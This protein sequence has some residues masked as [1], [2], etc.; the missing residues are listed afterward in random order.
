MNKKKQLIVSCF[1]K[2]GKEKG[3]DEINVMELVQACGVSR[4]TF[5]YHFRDIPDVIE[6]SVMERMNKLTEES[7]KIEDPLQAIE[8]ITTEII[9]RLQYLHDLL[10]T[11]WRADVE[12]IMYKCERG[13]VKRIIEERGPSL[14]LTYE[15]KEFLIDFLSWG[16]IAYFVRKG[17]NKMSVKTYSKQ[18]YQLIGARLG[19][20]E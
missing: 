8:F 18:F 15:E 1:E 20:I 14:S 13:H 9:Q 2:L 17:Y 3:F 12:Q 5:Y 7:L 4:T 11:K 10:E 6:A 19:C 16:G